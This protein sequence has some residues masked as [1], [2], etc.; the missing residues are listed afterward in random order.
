MHFPSSFPHDLKGSL[1][2]GSLSSETRAEEPSDRGKILLLIG[3]RACDTVCVLCA[4]AN[5][6]D[7]DDDD[8]RKR[9]CSER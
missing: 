1:K 3:H 9:S 5:D 7:D 4:A 6:G 8:D 2:L